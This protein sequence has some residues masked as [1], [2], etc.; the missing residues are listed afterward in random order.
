MVDRLPRYDDAPSFYR[1]TSLNSMSEVEF[2]RSIVRLDVV[3]LG[4]LHA[5]L[6]ECGSLIAEDL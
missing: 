5:P 2:G 6:H 3:I 4:V 1:R